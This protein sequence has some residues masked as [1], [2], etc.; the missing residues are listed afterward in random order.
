MQRVVVN[1]ITKKDQYTDNL[2]ALSVY[3]VI[4]AISVQIN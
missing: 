3:T 4:I 2:L 1:Y